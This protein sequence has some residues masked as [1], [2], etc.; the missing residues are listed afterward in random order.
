MNTTSLIKAVSV[1][2]TER[3]IIDHGYIRCLYSTNAAREIESAEGCETV[4]EGT[5]GDD[6]LA[7]ELAALAED[8]SL[9]AALDEQAVRRLEKAFLGPDITDYLDRDEEDELQDLDT[10]IDAARELI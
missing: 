4:G 8:A 1:L 6:N 3:K 9:V 10:L 2:V 5:I 7:A